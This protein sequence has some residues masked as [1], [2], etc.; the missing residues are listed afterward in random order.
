MSG[1][2]TSRSGPPVGTRPDAIAPA[3]VPRK[4]GVITEDAAKIKPKNLVFS[5]EAV[6]LRNAKLAPRKTIPAKASMSGMNSVVIAAAKAV[7][8]AVRHV[9]STK[10]SHT[11]LAAHAGALPWS[12]SF[13]VSVPR[14]PPPT[15]RT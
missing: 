4:N 9:N 13:R 8:K 14:T 15:V 7:G 3:T 12:T 2:S 1:W 11:L 5:K 6:Y 10:I